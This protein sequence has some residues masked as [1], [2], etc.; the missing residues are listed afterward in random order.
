MFHRFII[1]LGLCS[2]WPGPA[3]ADF[4]LTVLHTNDFHVC[5]EPISKY[6]G[7]CSAEHNSEGKCFGGSARLVNAIAEARARAQNSILVDGVDQLQG[8]LFCTNFKGKLAAE[9]MNKQRYDGMSLSNHE[10]D[11]AP[12]RP[13]C[14]DPRLTVRMRLS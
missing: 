5:F 8:S 9:L 7:G 2:L 12:E 1:L 3:Q 6:Q 13:C 11:N 10:L 4:S 14:T